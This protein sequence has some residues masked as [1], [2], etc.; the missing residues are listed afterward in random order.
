MT[1]YEHNAEQF[2]LAMFILYLKNKYP[3][4][5][6]I[7]SLFTAKSHAYNSSK[8]GKLNLFLRLKSIS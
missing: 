7:F 8:L 3:T 2:T 5:G 6:T 1:A 4:K